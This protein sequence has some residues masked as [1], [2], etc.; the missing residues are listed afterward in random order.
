M[1]ADKA[2]Y[3]IASISGFNSKD[4]IQYLVTRQHFSKYLLKIRTIHE[5]IR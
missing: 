1:R 3:C 2:T 4:V 5:K